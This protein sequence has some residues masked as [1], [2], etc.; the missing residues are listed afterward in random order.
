[1]VLKEPVM[2]VET[3]AEWVVQQ[4]QHSQRYELIH[5]EIVELSPGR[6]SNSRLA[7]L[8]VAALY[9]YC[10][11]HHIPVYTSGG[12]GAYRIGG[13]V[14]APDFA[15]KTTP[16]SDEFPDPVPP[17]WA[18]EIISPTDR[19]DHIRDKRMIYLEAGILLW[20]IYP[21]SKVIDV[22]AP[23]QPPRAYT[24]DDTLDTTGVV[25]GFTLAL[26]DLFR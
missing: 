12:D 18:V 24:I 14:I 7:H 20:E 15:Y 2:T 21:Q 1:M 19:P 17:A 6:T 9:P 26:K 3:F 13:S 5:G 10:L 16:M 11:E 8:L 22:Y 23:G 25:P 4:G